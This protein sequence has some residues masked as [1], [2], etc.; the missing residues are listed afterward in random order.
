MAIE[1]A[2]RE[3][4]ALCA[5]CDLPVPAGL[6]EPDADA[7]FCCRG[8]KTVH[9]LIHAEGL[10]AYYELR[11]DDRAS[12]A[13]NT[14]ASYAAYDDPS[15]IARYGKP[16][17]GGRLEVPLLLEGVHCSAC[18]WLI[19]T[20]MN[21]MDGV[22]EARLTFGRA[23]LQ[24]IFNPTQTT[25]RTLAERLAKLGYPPH[26][27]KTS[28]GA[29]AVQRTE[30]NLWV[31]LGIAGAV[32]GNVMLM[33]FALYGGW[34]SGMSD[35]FAELFRWGSLLVTLPSITYAAWPFYRGAVAGL[36]Q[37][38]LHMDLPISIG[39][40]VGFVGGCLN[41]LR[42]TGEIY[43]DSVCALI[44]LLLIGRVLQVRQQRRAR[45]NTELLYALT[46]SSARRLDAEGHAGLVAIETLQVGDLIEVHPGETFATDGII[47]RGTSTVDASLL[48]GEA[49]PVDV[50][51]GDE[52]FGGTKNLQDN[53]TV[54]V[55]R[56]VAEARVAKIAELVARAS[57]ERAPVVQLADRVAG[58]FVAVV[59]LLAGLTL[60]YW[61]WVE[62]S[63]A[64]DHAVALLVVS[65]PCALGLATPLAMT[66]AISKAARR[67]I[68]PKSGVALEALGRMTNTTVVF[69]KTGTLTEGRM[70]VVEADADENIRALTAAAEHTSQHPVGRALRQHL[71]ASRLAVDEL[72]T[73]N[74][75]GLHATIEG[76]RVVI[77]APEFVRK[78]SLCG[79]RFFGQLDDWTARGI[80]PVWVAI[81]GRVRGAFGLQDT[82]RSEARACVQ[83]LQKEGFAVEILS[84]D[85]PAVVHA[86][87][88]QLGLPAERCRGGQSPEDKLAVVQ[89]HGSVVMVGDGVNDSAAL[90]AATVGIAVH[91]G[92]E[93]CLSAADVFIRKEGIGAVREL[94]DGARS[95]VRTIN[96]TVIFSLG[97]NAFGAG[98]A[99]AGLLHP[100]VAAILMPISSLVVV[101]SSFSFRFGPQKTPEETS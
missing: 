2:Q 53:L 70:T 79:H 90:A 29:Q 15:F 56:E 77:G 85:H 36:S 67:G 18:L 81:D 38:V 71:G 1:I 64:I 33:A 76:H 30:R 39:I 62:P 49:M 35:E 98:L 84:G 23:H 54:T 51:V 63:M 24:L 80:T 17:E 65:C 78:Q 27:A 60:A 44:F 50:S 10:D 4:P 89:S 37:R 87:G 16:L 34:F 86:I 72:K 8:C 31:R 48:S 92:A 101:T 13:S 3:A 6:I 9:G 93:S 26:P 73:V 66:A 96:R 68:L 22:V 5:H 11:G 61:S 14:D 43:F 91:G 75:G 88:R 19:E 82:L 100:V 21:R 59:L 46:P 32:L 74:G 20:A 40:I 7:Q 97:Y 47:Q 42:G 58:V 55:T 12:P 28:A 94:I 57:A 45:E 83:G 41:T 95:T 25:L 69:D 52:V 99:M